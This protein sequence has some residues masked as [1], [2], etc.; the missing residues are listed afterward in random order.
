MPPTYIKQLTRENTLLD[1][2]LRALAYSRSVREV[3]KA[4][5][6][7]SPIVG[8]GRVTSL[9]YSPLEYKRQQNII[10]KEFY[11]KNT[12]NMAAQIVALLEEGYRWATKYAQKNITKQQ[13]PQFYQ[14]FNV[15]HA[16]ARGAI[17]YGYWG[18]PSLTA[19]LRKLLEKKVDRA[20]LDEILSILSTPH[21]VQGVL[22]KLHK[23][24][25][26]LQD[27]RRSL[28]QKLQLTPQEQELAL[29]LSW[30]TFLYEMGERVASL[31]YDTLLH[32]LSLVA[33]DDI[34]F[35]ELE[36]YDSASLEDYFK[37]TRLSKAEIEQRKEF[38]ILLMKKNAVVVMTGPQAR[39]Y[40]T[41]YFS[42][43]EPQ[44][45]QEV[46]GVVAS[47]GIAKG[48]VKII[49]TEA[50]QQKMNTGDILVS[51]MTTP[52][53]LMAVKQAAAIVTDEGGLTAHAAIVARELGIPCIVGT[54]Y[55]TKIFHDGDMV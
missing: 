52:R 51:S 1:R 27:A 20:Q 12:E 10:R 42:E 37:G 26:K 39:A 18:E 31:L 9:Y 46:R 36:W 11:G 34:V 4:C 13:F 5:I 33:E 50:D 15:H 54:Q 32:H 53:L 43:E 19:L 41:Q 29:I 14:A 22:S 40:Y 3:G 47:R 17:V 44:K 6:A 30:F 8:R 25:Q 23:T 45:A 7:K 24:P 35:K 21:S 28:I 16:H 49:I 2:S 38:Y 55:A 48:R